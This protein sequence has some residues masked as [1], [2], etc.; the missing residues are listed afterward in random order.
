MLATY[1]I[2]NFTNSDNLELRGMVHDSCGRLVLLV[3]NAGSLNFQH[4]MTID[5]ARDFAAKLL[6]AADEVDQ[7]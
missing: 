7:A 2:P 5:Q 3:Q 4:S 6:A 1:L